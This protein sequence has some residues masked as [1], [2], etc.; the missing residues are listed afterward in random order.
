[1]KNIERLH[2]Y[3][4]LALLTAPP[5]QD[6]VV[7][8]SKDMILH[9]AVGMASEMHEVHNALFSETSIGDSIIPE[10]G[11]VMWY[12]AILLSGAGLDMEDI[13]FYSLCD[14]ID[15][16]YEDLR[17]NV[18][19]VLDKAKRMIFYNAPFEGSLKSVQLIMACIHMIAEEHDHSL[20]DVATLNIEKLK[21]RYPDKYSDANAINRNTNK[22]S[23]VF[24]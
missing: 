22:E 8:Y 5:K 20:E 13:E 11:D 1:M 2:D 12:M 6:R 17:D 9:G 19:K 10:L 4:K 7:E 24:G 14:Q 23:Q 18:S 15:E 16:P 21:V 3:Q